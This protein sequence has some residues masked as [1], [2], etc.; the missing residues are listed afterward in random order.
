MYCVENFRKTLDNLTEGT[1][2]VADQEPNVVTRTAMVSLY[3]LCFEQSWKAMKSI[4]D[5][6]GHVEAQSGS[7]TTII[8]L[9]YREGMIDDE[10]KW[11]AMLDDRRRGIH[12]YNEAIAN[13]I[14][15]AVPQYI[16]VFEKLRSE[17]ETNWL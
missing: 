17:L 7:P 15:A 12:I 8:K 10:D 13:E 4:L 3:A 6:A 9:A 14:A 1:R 5:R 11:L 16:A 2:L